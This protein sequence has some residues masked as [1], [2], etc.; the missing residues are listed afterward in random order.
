MSAREPLPPLWAA[1]ARAP[2][3]AHSPTSRSAAARADKG[4]SGRAK[5]AV[6]AAIAQAGEG[7]L[8]DEE[9]IRATGLA[10]ST[11]RPRRVELVESGNVRDSG[12]TRKT[13][14]GCAAVVWTTRP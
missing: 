11:Y 2:F 5:L 4:L 13:L 3:Q 10:A 7:G 14:S 8:T 9:G 12:F 1:A 6:L